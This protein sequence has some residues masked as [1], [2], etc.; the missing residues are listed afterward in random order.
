MPATSALAEDDDVAAPQRAH[1][2]SRLAA[3]RGGLVTRQVRLGVSDGLAQS[4][5]L[6]EVAQAAGHLLLQP[7]QAAALAARLSGQLDNAAV[8]LELGEGLLEHLTDPR[9]RHALEQVDGHV[10]GRAEGRYQRVSAPGGQRGD[11]GRL[12]VVGG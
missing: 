10:V 2:P 4:G 12:D 5:V 11:R 6:P 3:A 8:G 9:P 1:R 7:L